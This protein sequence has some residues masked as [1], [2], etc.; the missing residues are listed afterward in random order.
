MDYRFLD[1]AT[2]LEWIGENRFLEWAEFSGHYYGTPRAPVEK[3]LADGFDVV[4]EIEVQGAMKVREAVPDA[5]LIFVEP[6]SLAALEERL[7]ARGDTSDI[8]RR[9]ETARAELE[10]ADEFDDRIVNDELHEAV[11][12]VLSVLARPRGANE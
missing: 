7:R 12:E 5:L 2:F 9:L 4:L 3:R 1:E 6:P 10:L 8:A 11:G